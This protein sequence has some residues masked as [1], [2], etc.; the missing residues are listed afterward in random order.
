MHKFFALNTH[1]IHQRWIWAHL[2]YSHNILTDFSFLSLHSFGS[3]TSNV[4]FYFFFSKSQVKNLRF[5]GNI[6]D[7]LLCC[8]NRNKNPNWAPPPSVAPARKIQ[9][10]S[11]SLQSCKSACPT[12]LLLAKA[13]QERP[14]AGIVHRINEG[15]P[16]IPPYPYIHLK[17]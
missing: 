13:V 14:Y 8:S 5:F 16:T 11:R 17:K 3:G 15:R 10:F 2:K 4:S 7:I 1:E 12:S 9:A 6:A